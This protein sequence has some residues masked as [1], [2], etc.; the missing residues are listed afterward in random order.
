MVPLRDSWYDYE[1]YYGNNAYKQKVVEQPKIEQQPRVLKKEK[2]KARNKNVVT[3]VV[4][5]AVA[6]SIVYRYTLINNKNMEIIEKREELNALNNVNSQMLLNMERSM[7]MAQIEL[8]ATEQ[9]GLQKPQNYQV[10]YIDIPK[11][12]YVTVEN[13]IKKENWLKKMIV[14]VIDFLVL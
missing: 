7:D 13:D 12:D 3:G 1:E 2:R 4:I 5:F 14:N 6:L 8:Y 10:A 11:S 9:L